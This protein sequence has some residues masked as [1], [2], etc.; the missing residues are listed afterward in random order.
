MKVRICKYVCVLLSVPPL[1]IHF[2][3][4]SSL[5]SPDLDKQNW[6]IALPLHPFL[7]ILFILSFYFSSLSLLFLNYLLIISYS[8]YFLP[9]IFLSSPSILIFFLISSYP[10][11]LFLFSSLYLI[12]YCSYFLPLIFL[13]FP[14]LLIFFLSLS[15]IAKEQVITSP[16]SIHIN[17]SETLT[18][19]C[20]ATGYPNPSITWLYG[21]ESALIL[22]QDRRNVT[23]S[24][25]NEYT[26]HSTLII[27]AVIPDDAGE[28]KCRAQ[29]Q[30]GHLIDSSYVTVEGMHVCIQYYNNYYKDNRDGFRIFTG[31]CH[32]LERTTVSPA[33]DQWEWLS[34]LRKI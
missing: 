20:T 7:F 33:Q 16:P 31:W 28:Y 17:E 34:S 14:T 22:S 19:Q 24:S 9:L 6:A 13:S 2:S 11:L 1:F 10:L 30:N 23:D 8:S 27:V 18:L 12:F 15:T 4:Y 5:Y 3:L 21:D 29:Y 32:K 25:D 26:V